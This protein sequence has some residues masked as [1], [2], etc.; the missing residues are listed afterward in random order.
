ML[1]PLTGKELARKL[2]GK[3]LET[4]MGGAEHLLTPFSMVIYWMPTPIDDCHPENMLE[5]W[6]LP[7]K[8]IGKEWD[9]ADVITNLRT[10]QVA[11]WLQ[12]ALGD[13]LGFLVQ[14]ST[15][16]LI[17]LNNYLNFRLDLMRTIQ[18]KKNQLLMRWL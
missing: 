18:G 10:D 12:I 4:F 8:T 3:C 2:L 14:A 11:H 13:L 9:T 7:V 5:L 17:L 6:T 16:E 15:I 1:A